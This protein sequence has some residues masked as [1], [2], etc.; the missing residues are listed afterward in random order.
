MNKFYSA[1]DFCYNYIVLHTSM[2]CLMAFCPK[3]TITKTTLYN[4]HQLCTGGICIGQF[5]DAL[6]I[7]TPR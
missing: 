1:L 7:F 6:T 2:T 4:A 3:E 5:K